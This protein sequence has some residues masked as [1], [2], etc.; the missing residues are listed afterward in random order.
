MEKYD[1]LKKAGQKPSIIK[2]A[3]QSN[4]SKR[5]VYGILKQSGLKVGRVVASD[6]AASEWG[7]R[8]N[9]GGTM[10]VY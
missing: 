5:F 4:V 9:K 1:K 7:G 2:L 6:V 10:M 3:K 8:D